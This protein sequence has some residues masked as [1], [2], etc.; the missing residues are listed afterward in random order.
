MPK[1]TFHQ[2][3]TFYLLIQLICGII[4]GFRNLLFWDFIFAFLAFLFAWSY[5][6]FYYKFAE[7]LPITS[8]EASVTTSEEFQ[9]VNMFP[10]V[11][12]YSCLA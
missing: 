3:P 6:K 1:I 10:Q 5:L 7:S 12:I 4:L 8:T 11:C 2:V 9:F